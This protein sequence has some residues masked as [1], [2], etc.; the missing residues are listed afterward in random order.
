MQPTAMSEKYEWW[1]NVSRAN[2]FD[3]CTSMNGQLHAEQRVAQRDA[4]VGEAAG[5]DDGE[6]DAIGLGRLDA[7][8]EFV[9]GVALE[10][11]QLMAEL[12]G[13]DLGAFFDGGQRVRPVDFGLALPEQVQVRT[14]E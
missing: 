12:V 2:V 1:R 10:G 14:V 6:S 7:I 4:G 9:F 5:I 13:G 3:R 8:D 11:H